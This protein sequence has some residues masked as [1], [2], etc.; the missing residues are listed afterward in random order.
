MCSLGIT[1]KLSGLNV[2]V[3]DTEGLR[4]KKRHLHFFL[5]FI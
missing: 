4:E 5:N 1:D 2:T 3:A